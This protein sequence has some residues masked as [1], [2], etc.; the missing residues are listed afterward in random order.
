MKRAILVER[1]IL[2]LLATK[3]NNIDCLDLRNDQ[4]VPKKLRLSFEEANSY[5]AKS[6]WSSLYTKSISILST[7]AFPLINSP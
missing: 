1:R 7:M 3:V 4:Y 6:I 2:S 5:G